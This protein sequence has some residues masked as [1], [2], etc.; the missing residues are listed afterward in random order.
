MNDTATPT[1]TPA[2]KEDVRIYPVLDAEGKPRYVKARSIYDA[3][4]HVFRPQV[5]K[6]LTGVEVA[7]LYEDGGRVETAKKE[8]Q[9]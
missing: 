5:G 8:V 1:T 3:V 6:P 2:A 9:A 4:V 7:Q